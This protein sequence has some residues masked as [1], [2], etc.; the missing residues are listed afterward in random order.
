MFVRRC[1][2]KK[3]PWIFRKFRRRLATFLEKRLRT[4]VS[5]WI[6]EIY[7]CMRNI[8][9][10]ISRADCCLTLILNYEDFETRC[11]ATTSLI[12][13]FY[14]SISDFW[15]KL[16]N[17]FLSSFGKVWKFLW[18]H[19]SII[20]SGWNTTSALP[21]LEFFLWRQAMIQLMYWH[22]SN[23]LQAS[24]PQSW[25]LESQYSNKISPNNSKKLIGD[26]A[27]TT[28][29]YRSPA[30]LCSSAWFLVVFLL[31]L[32]FL[33]KDPIVIQI[34]SKRYDIKQVIVSTHFYLIL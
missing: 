15:K 5:L 17:I 34:V 33:C 9:Y 21:K 32:H 4:S 19:V 18:W 23:S 26:N 16:K 31:Y 11:E 7:L 12:Q 13:R 22:H 6:C 14:N 10:R 27:K 1:P 30:V 8:F 20:Y 28:G 24:F 25:K 2:E 29:N 3:C